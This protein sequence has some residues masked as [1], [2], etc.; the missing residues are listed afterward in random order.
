MLCIVIMLSLVFVCI[1]FV[2]PVTLSNVFV[3]IAY[4]GVSLIM[5]LFMLM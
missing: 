3:V 2:V 4:V 5:L 1:A